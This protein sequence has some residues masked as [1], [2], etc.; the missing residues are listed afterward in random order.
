MTRN[1]ALYLLAAVCFV[2]AVILDVTE[3]AE[4][5]LTW[6]GWTAAGLTLA[7]LPKLFDDKP[8]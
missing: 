1:F 7:V 5:L 2:V 3:E 8:L 4:F 6:N